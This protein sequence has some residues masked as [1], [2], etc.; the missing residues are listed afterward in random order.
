[1]LT[2]QLPHMRPSMSHI[3]SIKDYTK[4]FRCIPFLEGREKAGSCSGEGFLFRQPT[5]FRKLV[6]Q[7]RLFSCDQ[8][9]I[10]TIG[11]SI[12]LHL[13]PCGNI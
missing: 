6:L 2:L 5:H 10:V 9:V 11:G 4:A 1:M 8:G 13:G 7:L 12:G 3:C